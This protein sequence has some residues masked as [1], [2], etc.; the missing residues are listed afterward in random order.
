MNSF[1]DGGTQQIDILD[2]GGNFQLGFV[3]CFDHIV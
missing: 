1:N 2:I 3:W